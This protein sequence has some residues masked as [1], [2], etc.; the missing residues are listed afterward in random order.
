MLVCVW[1]QV[2][3]QKAQVFSTK[4]S[5]SRCKRWPFGSQKTAFCKTGQG[6]TAG[7]FIHHESRQKARSSQKGHK[8]L[9]KEHSAH[10]QAVNGH[11]KITQKAAGNILPQIF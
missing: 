1:L 2:Y 6:K 9:Q 8:I 5:V 3:T 11:G 4:S 7:S 10:K